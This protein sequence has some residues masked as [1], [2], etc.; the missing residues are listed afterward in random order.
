M[1]RRISVR[2]KV[3]SVVTADGTLE[4]Q[5]EDEVQITAGACSEGPYLGYFCPTPGKGKIG[6]IGKVSLWK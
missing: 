3:D 6:A 4:L 5:R 1:R 2:T